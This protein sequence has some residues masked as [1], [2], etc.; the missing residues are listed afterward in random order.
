VLGDLNLDLILS[1]MM[2]PPALGR[3]ILAREHCFK[4]GGSAANVAVVLAMCGA[5]V[6]LFACV[7]RDAEG[8]VALAD[9][10]RRGLRTNTVR[11]LRDLQTAVTVSLT[12]PQDRI[13]VTGPGGLPLTGLERFKKGYLRAGAHLHLGSYFLQRALRPSVASLLR[14]A[15]RAGMTTSLDPGH[16]PEGLWELRELEEALPALDWLVPNAAETIALAGGG[17]LEDALGRLGERWQRTG[18]IV[19]KA[20]AEGAWLWRDGRSVHF[21]AVPARA[22][23]ATCAGDCFDAGFLYALCGGAGPEEAVAAGNRLGALGASCLGLPS[24]ERV[25]EQ[26][27]AAGGSRERGGP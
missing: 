7:G 13:Y 16:D 3:E 27:R 15:R 5:P 18:G 11:K 2:E 4:A 8:A 24:A 14:A 6:R 23:D 21:P 19:A 17:T 22:V 1:G 12:Y 25:R 20:G 10:R 9:L 26:G